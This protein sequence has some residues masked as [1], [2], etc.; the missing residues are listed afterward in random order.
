M[1]SLPCDRTGSILPQKLVGLTD[2]YC[3]IQ[4][5]S[6]STEW[7]KYEAGK[8]ARLE[9]VPEERWDGY[10][11]RCVVT[12]RKGRQA[13]SES[14]TVRIL[15][16]INPSISISC[17]I[18][19]GKENIIIAEAS[20]FTLEASTENSIFIQWQ[21]SLDGSTFSDIA[22]ENRT[23]YTYTNFPAP[24]EDQTVYYRAIA[25]SSTGN[26]AVSNVI[27]VLLLSEDE[28]PIRPQSDSVE[29]KVAE[30]SELET[31]SDAPATETE[32]ADSET[33][34]EVEDFMSDVSANEQ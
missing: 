1:D 23:S 9:I 11:F 21:S 19:T 25:T 7:M 13:T 15:K 22:V 4:G 12:D 2:N 33:V 17:D 34:D 6:T 5:N 24:S 29:S 14:G 31:V 16:S 26:T 32:A 10:Q 20:S 27:E 28:L 8:S 30:N 18:D 3:D